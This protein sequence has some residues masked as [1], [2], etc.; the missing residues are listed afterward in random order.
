MYEEEL[1]FINSIKRGQL[2]RDDV[3]DYEEGTKTL[4]VTLAT[5]LSAETN[6]SAS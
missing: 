3:A 6:K 2:I 4:E 1:H 5:V